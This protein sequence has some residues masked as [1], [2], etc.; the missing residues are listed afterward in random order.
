MSDSLRPHELQHARPPCP[1]QTPGVHSNSCPS[2][3]WCHPAISSSVVPFSSC[4]QSLPASGTFPVSQLFAWGGQSTGVSASVSSLQW[5]PRAYLLQDGLVGSPCSPRD[6][7]DSSPTP[8]FKSIN[9]SAVNFLHSP[10]LTSINDH[11]KNHSLD[12]MD[13]HWQH[14]SI[15]SSNNMWTGRFNSTDLKQSLCTSLVSEYAWSNRNIKINAKRFSGL[16]D[17]GSDITIISKHLWPKSWP[18]QKVSCHI[19]GISQTKMQE[20]YQ[21]VQIYPCEGPV[22]QPGTLRPYVVSEW[23]EVAQLC[24]TLCHPV[25]CSPSGSSIHGILHAR[26][27]EWVA[28]SFSLCDKCT[29]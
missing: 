13:L 8:Q 24:P 9:F 15:N 20:V 3:R 12:Q 14:I 29:P 7:Q 6:S 26:I 16:L 22:G 21:S 11:W 10:T 25:D 2:S 4:P 27:L 19:A 23:S 5:T 17:T 18:I 28:I 1:S